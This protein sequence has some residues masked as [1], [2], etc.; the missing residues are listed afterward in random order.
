MTDLNGWSYDVQATKA[1]TVDIKLQQV[2]N[3]RQFPAPIQLGTELAKVL[4][5]DMKMATSTLTGRRV[6]GK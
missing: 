4:F 1:S 6:N 5:I 2:L 3:N